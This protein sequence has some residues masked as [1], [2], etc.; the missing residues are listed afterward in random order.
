MYRGIA[1]GVGLLDQFD[2]MALAN[3]ADSLAHSWIVLAQTDPKVRKFLQ[4]ITTGSGWGAVILAH[5][6]VALPIIQ[7]HNLIPERHKSTD[8]A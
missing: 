5:T 7:H 4:R 8:N 6:I 2:G 1:F 3:G